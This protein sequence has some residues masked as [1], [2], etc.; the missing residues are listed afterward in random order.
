[1]QLFMYNLFRTSS[2][3]SVKN[4]TKTLLKVAY[5]SLNVSI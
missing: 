2:E 5:L 4:D 1:M 3:N